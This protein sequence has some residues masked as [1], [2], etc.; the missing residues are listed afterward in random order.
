[1]ALEAQAQIK[2]IP[3]TRAGSLRNVLWRNLWW[4][5]QV[6]WKH[7]VLQNVPK[8]LVASMSSIGVL[9]L[10]SNLGWSNFW[11]KI[12]PTSYIWYSGFLIWGAFPQSHA[13]M[14]SAVTGELLARFEDEEL[15]D[16]SVK[17]LKQ[18]LAHKIGIPRFRLR[19]LHDNCPLDDDQTLT[20]QVVQLVKM[21]FLPPDAEE[22]EVIM[23]ACEQND[24]KLLEQHLNQPRNPNFVAPLMFWNALML[25]PLNVAAFV[26]SLQCT[27]LL[28]EAGAN[29]D[30]GRTD[31]GATPLS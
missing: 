7:K 9:W 2:P 13:R 18:R 17:A 29:I 24:D 22:D 19:L 6:T 28:I 20:V 12:F 25:T 26:G 27:S 5:P 10:R 14:L 3:L 21:E 4:T 31:S 11:F 1:M 15:A 8:T 16:A 23:A 30:Q